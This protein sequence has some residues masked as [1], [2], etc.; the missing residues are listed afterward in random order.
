[1]KRLLP[2]LIILASPW[3][4]ANSEQRLIPMQTYGASTILNISD[5]KSM[6]TLTLLQQVYE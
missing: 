4:V 2:V 1:M 5:S 6:L 3:A